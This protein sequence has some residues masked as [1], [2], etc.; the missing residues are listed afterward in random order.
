MKKMLNRKEGRESTRNRGKTVGQEL[1]SKISLS[2]CLRM[3]DLQ[4]FDVR[5][6]EDV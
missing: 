1:G 5:A 2:S 4:K 3:S 6:I